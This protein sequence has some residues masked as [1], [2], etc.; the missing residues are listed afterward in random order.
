MNDEA[1]AEQL[2]KSAAPGQFEEVAQQLQTL[3]LR[4]GNQ[5]PKNYEGLKQEWQLSQGVGVHK[6]D[7][8]I[9]NP[10]APTVREKLVKY[11]KKAYGGGGHRFSTTGGRKV[12][13]RVWLLPGEETPSDFRVLS[14]ATKIDP[15]NLQTGHWKSTWTIHTIG[16]R[17]VELE[18]TIEIHTYTYEDGNTQLEFEK[19]FGPVLVE[20]LVA[21]SPEDDDEDNEEERKP[22]LADGILNQIIHWEHSMLGLMR[23]LNEISGDKLKKIR[24]VLP[25]TKT[26]MNWEIEAQRSVQH[27]KKTAQLRDYDDE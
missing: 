26:K 14:Y 21:A 15:N 5:V 4:T 3:L 10:L 20:P 6:T 24:R 12:S 13:A 11:Q 17:E 8:S 25:I 22:S 9:R 2:L 27:L 19:D 18:G 1:A 23:G 7:A 16:P